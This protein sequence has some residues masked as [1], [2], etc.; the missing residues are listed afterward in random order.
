VTVTTRLVSPRDADAARLLALLTEEIRQ[1]YADRGEDGSGGF[2]IEDAEQPGSA[3]IVAYADDAAIGCGALRPYDAEAGEVKRMF[4]LPEYRGRGVAALIL[5]ALEQ[6]AVRADYRVMR[7]ETGDRQ[8][9]A[10]RVYERAG[11]RRSP[12][13]GVYVN[14]VGSLC[15]VKE[16]SARSR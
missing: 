5:T 16:L 1:M 9:S 13:Y 12:P 8:P 14:W 3:F 4:V 2:E 7:L 11:Y 15:F 6:E 10:V